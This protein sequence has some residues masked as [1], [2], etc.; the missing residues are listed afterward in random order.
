MRGRWRTTAAALAAGGMLGGCFSY[1]PA[2]GAPVTAGREVRVDFT[3]AGAVAMTGLVGPRIAAITGRVVAAADSALTLAVI[4]S[5][6]QNGVEDP[7]NGE[8][9]TVRRANIASVA[10]RTFSRGRTAVAL[11]ILA[12]VGAGLGAVFGGGGGAS[13]TP[14]GGTGG[15]R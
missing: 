6:K 15:G 10:Q 7:W 2:P 3:D 11:G 5:I 9:V 4:S 1:V 13:G 12:A 14:T 8:Q